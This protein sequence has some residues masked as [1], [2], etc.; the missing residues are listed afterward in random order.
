M[1]VMGLTLLLVVHPRPKVSR[2]SARWP[3]GQTRLSKYIVEI[4]VVGDVGCCGKQEQNNER[5]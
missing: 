5:I 4:D 3:I 2:A 1:K